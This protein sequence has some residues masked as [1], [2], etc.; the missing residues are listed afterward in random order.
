M[1][2]KPYGDYFKKLDMFGL[3]VD[4]RINQKKIHQTYLGASLSIILSIVV[5]IFSVIEI[6][7]VFNRLE[8]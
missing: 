4:V 8:P 2:K 6:N 1:P 7:N 3:R 5:S